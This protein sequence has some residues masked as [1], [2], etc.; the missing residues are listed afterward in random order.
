MA[1]GDVAHRIYPIN[2]IR[3]RTGSL[4]LCFCHST[5][6]N[7]DQIAM[8]C[9]VN[10]KPLRCTFSVSVS[11]SVSSFPSLPLSPSPTLFFPLSFSRSFYNKRGSRTAMFCPKRWLSRSSPAQE[12]RWLSSRRKPRREHEE[13]PNFG[14]ITN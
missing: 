14:L 8:S 3:K 13:A 9:H 6:G 4:D 11:V 10:L 12:T 5:H 1:F 7:S 2:C